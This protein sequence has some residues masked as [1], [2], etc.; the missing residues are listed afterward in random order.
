[1]VR[2]AR[3]TRLTT[4]SGFK[5]G[6]SSGILTVTEKG[7]RERERSRERERERQINRHTEA[8]CTKKVAI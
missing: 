2:M 6:S 1:M 7:V 8:Q 4:R 3:T 5:M